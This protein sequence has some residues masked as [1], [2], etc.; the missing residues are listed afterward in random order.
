[1]SVWIGYYYDITP[2]HYAQNLTPN[3]IQAVSW[4]ATFVG[5]RVY[6][7]RIFGRNWTVC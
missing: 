4:N 7:N 5:S 3:L 1:M 2:N 6:Y